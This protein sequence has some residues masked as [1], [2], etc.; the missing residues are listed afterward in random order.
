MH[1][2]AADTLTGANYQSARSIAQVMAAV[3]NAL[4]NFWLIPLY[5]WHG[6][7]WATIASEC[8]LMIFLWAFVFKY[9]R[10]PA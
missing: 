10:Q 5:A 9:S 4:L 7:I 2:F 3:I 6:A 1:C 8:L